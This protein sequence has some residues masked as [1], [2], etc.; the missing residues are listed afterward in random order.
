MDRQEKIERIKNKNGKII[1]I[2]N[3]DVDPEYIHSNYAVEKCECVL[4]ETGLLRI[5]KFCPKDG[6][7]PSFF[8]RWDQRPHEL[9][10]DIEGV[11]QEKIHDFKNGKNGYGGH[12][13][14][15]SDDPARRKFELQIKTPDELVFHGTIGFSVTYAQTVSITTRARVSLVRLATGFCR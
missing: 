5:A 6:V 8:A 10:I 7:G 15:K 2:T 4:T 1:K 9:D 12:H 3:V 14:D 11:S 13:T